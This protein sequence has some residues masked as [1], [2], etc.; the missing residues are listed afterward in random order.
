MVETPMPMPRTRTMEGLYFNVREDLV[1][2]LFPM[3][4]FQEYKHHHRAAVQF[5]LQE[6]IQDLHLP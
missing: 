6:P 2:F 1:R 4:N 5:P 3:V